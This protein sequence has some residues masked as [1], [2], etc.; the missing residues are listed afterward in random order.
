VPYVVDIA[1]GGSGIMKALDWTFDK[2]KSGHDYDLKMYAQTAYKYAAIGYNEFTNAVEE[3]EDFMEYLSKL[4]GLPGIGKDCSKTL[5]CDF[6]SGLFCGPYF[7][8]IPHPK[9]VL[10]DL[11]HD[12]LDIGK[13]F[14]ALDSGI[15]QSINS[16][17]S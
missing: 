3:Y 6:I 2:V 1:Q 7:K 13:V 16:K 14:K 9:F 8:C 4:L 10:D 17:I 11:F 5:V 12:V 15:M